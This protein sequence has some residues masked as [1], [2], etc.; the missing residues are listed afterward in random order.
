M[1]F[2]LAF[3]LVSTSATV[4]Q[5]PNGPAV[6]LA[7]DDGDPGVSEWFNVYRAPAPGGPWTKLTFDP[8]PIPTLTYTD[9]NVTFGQT[10]Y[11][12]VTA[13]NGT[14]ESTYSAIVTAAINKP[15]PKPPVNPRVSFISII[16]KFFAWLRG[17]G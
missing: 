3:L 15:I 7:W 11:Y 13:G 4:L 5:T 14:G 2:L 10:W 12:A 9:T 16:A 8:L 1:I 17:L 6:G